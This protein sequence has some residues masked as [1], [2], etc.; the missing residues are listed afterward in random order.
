[1]EIVFRIVRFI[2]AA[3]LVLAV[4]AGVVYGLHH[5]GFYVPIATMSAVS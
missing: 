3:A 2:A 4:G 1:M 5:P